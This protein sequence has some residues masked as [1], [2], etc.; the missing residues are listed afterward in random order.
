[1]CLD[2]ALLA[3]DARSQVDVVEE[4]HHRNRFPRALDPQQ[5]CE[6]NQRTLPDR[7]SVP[8]ARDASQD[9]FSFYTFLETPLGLGSAKVEFF[10]PISHKSTKSRG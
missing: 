4:H 5:L 1:M 6:V 8:V 2:L 9:G 10:T 7:P 3:E